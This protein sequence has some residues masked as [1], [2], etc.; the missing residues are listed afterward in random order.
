MNQP[1][2]DLPI[3]FKDGFFRVH[4]GDVHCVF[5]YWS[6]VDTVVHT[7]REE[8]LALEDNTALQEQINC[9]LISVSELRFEFMGDEISS[10]TNGTEETGDARQAARVVLFS[11]RRM[12]ITPS[13]PLGYAFMALD[14]NQILLTA[15]GLCE[16]DSLSQSHQI[17]VQFRFDDVS[18]IMRPKLQ[19][20]IELNQKGSFGFKKAIDAGD[21]LITH[22]LMVTKS[23]RL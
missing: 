18:R 3:T 7:F 11:S 8:L 23:H 20:W 14:I 1:T 13:M 15:T 12:R 5:H 6:P 16:G 22:E 21:P 19:K 2:I 4:L 9:K 10:Q 17:V